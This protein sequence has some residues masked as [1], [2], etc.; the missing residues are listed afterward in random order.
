MIGVDTMFCKA[1]IKELGI[2]LCTQRRMNAAQVAIAN[3]ALESRIQID[4]YR[5]YLVEGLDI[6]ELARKYQKSA[7]HVDM[8]IRYKQNQ[9]LSKQC[10][11]FISDGVSEG[12][13]LNSYYGAEACLSV[14][15]P[16]K[17]KLGNAHTIDNNNIS[18]LKLPFKIYL[19]L[20]SEGFKTIR[21]IKT[22]IMAAGPAWYEGLRKI[23]YKEA[24]IVESSMCITWPK[25]IGLDREANADVDT[26]VFK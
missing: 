26:S 7:S 13:V 14:G 6:A 10:L 11:D 19:I 25:R 16:I 17:T 2:G 24:F 1:L 8:T 18:T 22:H 15:F 21:D 12:E 20:N 3:I 4:M 9:F 5:D 23:G